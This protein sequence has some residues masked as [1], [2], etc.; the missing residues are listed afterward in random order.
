M[1]FSEVERGT[2]DA[3]TPWEDPAWRE[4]AVAWVRTAAAETGTAVAIAGEGGEGWR[5][6][7]RPWSVVFRVPVEGAA[8]PLWFKANPGASRFEAAL[9]RSEERRVGEE[10]R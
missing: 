10:G 2:Y 3:V 1:L 9:A 5:V 4:E 6:R 7:L 8:D